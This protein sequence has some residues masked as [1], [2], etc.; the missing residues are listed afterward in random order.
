MTTA[1]PA[2]RSGFVAI[3]GRPSTGKSSLINAALGQP[4]APVSP[5]PQTTR[6]RQLGIL[7]L[8]HAQVI[9][10]DTPGIHTPHDRLGERM[11]AVARDMI[12]DTD[13][14]MLVFDLSA[15]PSA[16]DGLAVERVRASSGSHPILLAL[17]KSDLVDPADLSAQA[18]AYA[19]LLPEAEAW[20]V[21]ATRGDGCS[22]LIERLVAMLPFGPQYYPAEELTPTYERDLAGELIRAAAMSLLHGEVPHSVAVEVEE[23]KE[24]SEERAYV[25]AVLFVERESQKAIV[26]GRHGR[27]IHEIGTKSRKLIEEMSGRQIYLDLRVKVLRGWRQSEGALQQFGYLS[28]EQ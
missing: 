13:V 14:V 20:A 26:I 15:S 12:T 23:F 27:M 25:S 19:A 21:S 28:H 10:V 7:T 1:D 5:R 9:L 16:D 2:F 6:R 18:A 22:S 17:N 4:V 11:N 24:R 8:P 3:V